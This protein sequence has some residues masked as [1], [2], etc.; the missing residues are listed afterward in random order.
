MDKL[1]LDS[2]NVKGM[3]SMDKKYIVKRFLKWD[4]EIYTLLLQDVKDVEFTLDI[5]LKCIWKNAKVLSTKHQIRKGETS[6]Y[7]SPRW[8]KVVNT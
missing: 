4:K 7:V 8:K 1:K 5:T 3:E 2:W 6:I